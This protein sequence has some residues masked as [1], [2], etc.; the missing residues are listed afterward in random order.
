VLAAMSA[1]RQRIADFKQRYPVAV[2]ILQIFVI[3]P[4]VLAV[5]SLLFTGAM[6]F[7]PVRLTVEIV[8]GIIAAAL[9]I[10]AVLYR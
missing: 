7:Y 9:I 2:G 5:L 1:V 3:V 10:S 4:F 6:N 8:A